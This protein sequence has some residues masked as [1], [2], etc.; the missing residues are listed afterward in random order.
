MTRK[1]LAQYIDEYLTPDN[2]RQ[3][4]KT[5]DKFIFVQDLTDLPIDSKILEDLD[6]AFWDYCEAEKQ[7]SERFD[8]T[9]KY[10][11]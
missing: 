4:A 1:T 3:Y 2:A 9:N 8:F 6:L 11:R 5:M 10:D 7:E